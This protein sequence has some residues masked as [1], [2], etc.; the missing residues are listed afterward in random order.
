MTPDRDDL[1][2]KYLKLLDWYQQEYVKAG[3]KAGPLRGTPSTVLLEFAGSIDKED[4]RR[5][6]QVIEEECEQIDEES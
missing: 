6:E 3:R 2:P 4:L 5:M 1:P